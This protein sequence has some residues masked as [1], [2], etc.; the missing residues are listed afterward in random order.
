MQLTQ[1]TDYTLRVLMYLA[2]T[3]ERNV[4]ITEI[5]DFYQISR[6]H[7]VKIIHALAKQG[8]LHSMRG[9]HGGV[10]LAVSPEKIQLGALIRQTE[11][12]FALVECL[13][14]TPVINLAPSCAL[15]QQCGLKTVFDQ[16]LTAFF[17]ILDQY[18][19]ADTLKKTNFPL[20]N[21]DDFA[22]VIPIYEEVK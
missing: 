12:H 17:N 3:P 5:A 4:T 8:L 20:M 13:H 15:A 1:Y 9:K 18:T 16:A 21:Q 2:Q 19:L 6:N 22:S 14:R 10:R 7:L 11:N